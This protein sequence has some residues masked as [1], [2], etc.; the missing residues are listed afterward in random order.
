MEKIVEGDLKK[1]FDS[2]GVKCVNCGNTLN[3]FYQDADT[4]ECI[5][6]QKCEF[7]LSG[8]ELRRF[9]E[10]ISITLEVVKHNEKE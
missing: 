10:A 7:D 2:D 1:M 4:C 3:H 8:Y 9:V 6:C 5:E